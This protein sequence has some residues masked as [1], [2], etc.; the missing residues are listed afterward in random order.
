[1]GL[2]RRK[3]LQ[4]G[5]LEGEGYCVQEIWEGGWWICDCKENSKKYAYGARKEFDWFGKF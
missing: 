4:I 2:G 5:E 3:P 1:M